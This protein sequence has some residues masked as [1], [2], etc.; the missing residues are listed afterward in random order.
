MSIPPPCFASGRLGKVTIQ[1]ND[2]SIAIYPTHNYDISA[3]QLRRFEESI[4]K[5]VAIS[6]ETPSSLLVLLLGDFNIEP[7]DSQRIS[8]PNPASPGSVGD[9]SP[10]D[11]APVDATTKR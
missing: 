5:D 11:I 1:A 7:P 4:K 6:R 2:L 8:I 9:L 10:E 3:P